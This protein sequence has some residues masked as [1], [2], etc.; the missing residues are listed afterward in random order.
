MDKIKAVFSLLARPLDRAPMDIRNA[1]PEDA[2]AIAAIYNPYV[3]DSCITFE[4]EPVTAGEMAARISETKA[5]DLPWLLAIADDEVLGYAYASRWKGRCAYRLPSN[6][7]SIS[8]GRE[9]GKE[10]V[11]RCTP[12]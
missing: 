2:A 1:T 7:R 4:T 6:R 11:G 3:A 10:S 5:A 8:P 12:G 9:R